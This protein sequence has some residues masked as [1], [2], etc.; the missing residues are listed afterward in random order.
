MIRRNTMIS[1]IIH[2]IKRNFK[3]NVAIGISVVGNCYQQF[4][5]GTHLDKI[6]ILYDKIYELN[7]ELLRVNRELVIASIYKKFVQSNNLMEQFNQSR[8]D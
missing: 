8:R 2:N 6:T 1:R 3:L 4:L 5:I 7:Q